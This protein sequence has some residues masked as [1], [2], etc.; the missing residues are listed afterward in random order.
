MEVRDIFH[1]ES[2]TEHGGAVHSWIMFE[3]KKDDLSGGIQRINEFDVMAGG[4]MEPIL[5]KRM[6]K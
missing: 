4:A 3:K 1:L 6:E 2:F 5:I